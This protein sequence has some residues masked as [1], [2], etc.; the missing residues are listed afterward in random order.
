MP[1]RVTASSLRA[2]P[3]IAAREEAFPE[4][5]AV[6]RERPPDLPRLRR[7]LELINQRATAGPLR[8]DEALELLPLLGRAYEVTDQWADKSTLERIADVILSIL[9]LGI[10]PLVRY[11]NPNAQARVHDLA[12][13]CRGKARRLLHEPDLLLPRPEPALRTVRDG[14]QILTR[15]FSDAPEV[16]LLASGELSLSAAPSAEGPNHLAIYEAALLV[17]AGR[18]WLAG[19]APGLRAKLSEHLLRAYDAGRGGDSARERE[20]RS[21]S[22][23]LLLQLAV[24]AAR[25]GDQALAQRITTA[26]LERATNERERGLRVSMIHN[27]QARADALQLLPSD[28]AALQRLSADALP[29]APPYADWFKEGNRTLRI[30]HYMHH[31]FMILDAYTSRGYTQTDLGGGRYRLEGTEKDPNGKHPPIKVIVEVQTVEG[32][33]TDSQILETL[34]DPSVHMPIYTGHS[35]LGG[36]IKMALDAAPSKQVGGKLV[37]F[38][39]C[40]GQQNTPEF[41]QR[42]PNAHLVTTAEPMHI[43]GLRSVVTT[44]LDAIARREGYAYMRNEVSDDGAPFYP[45]DASAYRYRDEDRDGRPDVGDALYDVRQRGR[46]RGQNVFTPRSSPPDPS[47]IDALPLTN[48]V[49]FARTI[50]TYHGEHDA[51][52]P[53]PES[54]GERLISDGFFSDAANPNFLRITIEKRGGREYFRLA[55][56]ARYAHLSEGALAMRMLYELNRF[57]SLRRG[58]YGLAEKTRGMLLAYEWL[59]YMTYPNERASMVEGLAEA[60]GWPTSGPGP[61]MSAAVLAGYDAEYADTG[62][63]ERLLTSERKDAWSAADIR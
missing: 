40:R 25:Q 18:N 59:K 37:I 15:R 22:A 5:A 49:S 9:T 12:D 27:L 60:F 43:W 16:H 35:N 28:R 30:R 7:E 3:T 8:L 17:A 47:A 4:L 29:A 58:E 32:Y 57:F 13:R 24:E 45:D 38:G 31:E 48:A 23:T 53:M 19:T 52:S 11:L 21:G 56:N 2:A 46:G 50:L 44:A 1:L 33:S 10:L 20:L 42:H 39:M 36:N 54:T 51:R 34:D 55:I 26:Y 63:A 61:T 62:T 6:L 41:Y 14:H